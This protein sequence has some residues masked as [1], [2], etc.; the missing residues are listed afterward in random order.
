MATE[1]A[2]EGCVRETFGA[3]VAHHQAAHASDPVIASAM[4]T[5]AE[6]ETRHAAL[7]WAIARWADA[8][9]D[10]RA[11]VRVA[12]RR[13]KEVRRL[14]RSMDESLLG[15]GIPPTAQARQAR[16]LARAA[17]LPTPAQA[18]AL[19]LGAEALLWSANLV[20]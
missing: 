5:I 8:R 20:G 14:G 18:R 19:A 11:R 15:Q 17:G 6:D 12:R 1:N 2:V 16:S 10:E 9:L 13:R 4:R 3:L 7:A